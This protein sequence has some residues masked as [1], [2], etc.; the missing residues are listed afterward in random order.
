MQIKIVKARI[1]SFFL[2]ILYVLSLQS[3]ASGGVLVQK[4]ENTKAQPILYEKVISIEPDI[5]IID[6]RKNVEDYVLDTET[7][8]ELYQKYLVE[9]AAKHN[10]KLEVYAPNTIKAEE[11][12][13]FNS[14][15]PLKKHILFA[16]SQQEAK[17][18]E[19]D[20]NGNK[21]KLY[22]EHVWFQNHLEFDASYGHLAEK[23]GTPYF[24]LHGLISYKKRKIR[25]WIWLA[26]FPPIGINSFFRKTSETLYYHVVV[27]VVKGEIVHRELRSFRDQLSDNALQAI[28]YDSYNILTYKY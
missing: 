8:E 5:V 23:Y 17:V 20:Y 26:I 24:S 10:V 1:L 7:Q 2:A 18:E 15:L 9:S 6:Q 21:Y 16:M 13:Y 25:K 27:D 14:L 28:L 22:A 11:V 19:V 12:D 4:P 3:C